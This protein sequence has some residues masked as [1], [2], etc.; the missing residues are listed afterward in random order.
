LAVASTVFFSGAAFVCATWS[1]FWGLSAQ[2]W[3]IA[4]A[5]TASFILSLFAAMRCSSPLLKALYTIAAVWLGLLNF[6]LFAAL[7]CWIAHGV[8]AVLGLGLGRPGIAASLYGL[9]ALAAICGVANASWLRVTR[10]TVRLPNLP[11]SWQNREVVLVSDLHLGNVRG[12]GF[13]RRV[14]GK[15]ASLKPHAIFISGDMFDGPKVDYDR[16]AAPCR[17]LSAPAGVYFVTGNHE[18]YTGRAK[19]VAAIK[20]AGVRIIDNE[21]ITADGLQIA[22]VHDS[23]ALE[24]ES[25][26]G[27]L[28]G[29][30]LDRSRASILMAHRPAS[31]SIVDEAGISLQLSGHTH[32]GQFWPWCWVIYKVH[33]PFAYGLNRKGNL[34]VVTS[35]GAGTWGPPMRVGTRSEIVL[36]RLE[37]AGGAV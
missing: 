37:D 1:Y 34:Q 3:L 5:L 32:R 36:I 4:F 2:G 7:A 33:G 8:A 6:W 31:L 12:A 23:D 16:M 9:G 21:K 35:C 25:L 19:Y 18:E 24:P 17:E 30:A 10:M 13:M 27:I 20:K 26:R 11:A 29:M 15:I 22:G 28:A 14:A